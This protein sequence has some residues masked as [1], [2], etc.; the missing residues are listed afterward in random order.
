MKKLPP[1]EKIYEA[2]SA[3]ADERV[4]LGHE[5]ASVVSSSRTKTYTV[6]W[7]GNVYS[8]NDN[9]SY[10]QGYAGYPVLAVLMLQGVLRLNREITALFAGINWTQVNDAA[11][12]DYAK[13]VEMVF[14]QRG[15]GETTRQQARMEAEYIYEKLAGLDIV[16]KR[17]KLAAKLRAEG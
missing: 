10:W 8:S 12:R 5:K 4:T 11:R 13:A 1:I 6:S 3:V 15:F 7:A 17:G 9:A 16:I 14:N 2:F